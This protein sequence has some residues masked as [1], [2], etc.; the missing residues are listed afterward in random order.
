MIV[1]LKTASKRAEPESMLLNIQERLPV[2]MLKPSTLAC[3]YHIEQIQDYW[4]LQLKIR[5]NLTLSCQR[6]VDEFEHAFEHKNVLTIVKREEDAEKMSQDHEIIVA[7]HQ[8]I[9]IV[10][11]ITDELHLFVPE[12]HLQYDDCNRDLSKFLSQLV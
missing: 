6:C 2:N 10:D 11:V 1:C 4:T 5:G 9:N 12:H 3:E 8:T 7:D